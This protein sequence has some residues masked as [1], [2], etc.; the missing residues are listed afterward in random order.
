MAQLGTVAIAGAAAGHGRVPAREVG[1]G[2]GSAL[3]PPA[4]AADPER[5]KA[6]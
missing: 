1:K 6:A 4:D 2:G 5:A 3:A